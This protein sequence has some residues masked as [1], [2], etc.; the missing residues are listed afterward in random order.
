MDK[1]PAERRHTADFYYLRLRRSR[2][3]EKALA[4]W[5]E[6]LKKEAQAGK[7]CSVYFKHEDEGS[8]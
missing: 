7:E 8:P 4:K 2:Y 6:W 3:D 5:A 1:R